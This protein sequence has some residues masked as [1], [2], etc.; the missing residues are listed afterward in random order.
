[1][2]RKSKTKAKPKLADVVQVSSLQAARIRASARTI[3]QLKA[4]LTAAIFELTLRV[5]RLE[6]GHSGDPAAHAALAP[7][8]PTPTTDQPPDEPAPAVDEPA[9][10]SS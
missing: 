8:Q 2:K 9:E 5:K 1:M 10:Q 3:D 7:E 4:D 6:Q